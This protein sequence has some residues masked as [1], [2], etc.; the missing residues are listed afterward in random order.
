MEAIYQPT[1]ICAQATAAGHGAI[2][3]IRISGPSA[4][5]VLAEIF[6]SV[7]G[8]KYAELPARRMLFGTISASDGALIDE[9]LAVAF[10]APGSYTGEDSAEIYCHGSD[11]IVSELIKLLMA[12]GVRLASA[13]EFTKRAF[14]NGR[15]DLAQAE[16]VADLISS[17]TKAAHDVALNQMKGG[18]SEELASMRAELLNIVSLM[19]LELDFSEEDVEFADRSRLRSLVAEVSAH[20]GRLID[21]FALG[22]VIK[23]GVPVAIIGSTNTGKSTLLNALLREER[24]IVSDIAG[25]TRD[26]IE[27][28]VNIEGV[29]FRFIDTAGIRSTDETIE[30]IGIERTYSTLEKAS[31][32]LLMLDATRADSFMA[33]LSD[34]VPRLRAD[35]ELFVLVNKVDLVGEGAE[36]HS[37]TSTYGLHC[38][39]GGSLNADDYLSGSKDNSLSSSGGNNPGFSGS[40]ITN[41]NGVSADKTAETDGSPDQAPSAH[42]A[43]SQADSASD[44]MDFANKRISVDNVA[45]TDN[46]TVATLIGKIRTAAETLGLHPTAILPLCAKRRIG[47][48]ALCKALVASRRNLTSGSSNGTMVTNLRHY[49]ALCEARTALE[50]VSVGLDDCIPTEF[51]SMDIRSCIDAIGTITGEVSNDE[52]LGNIF[53]NF[54]IGK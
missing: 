34:L 30:R 32:V 38:D 35:Q 4:L 40:A 6:T 39:E 25:T 52:V 8:R 27:D 43:T 44:N 45:S 54:C 5:K 16:A 49:E 10:P 31:D 47:I 7:R 50:R 2:A 42:N 48:D 37:H 13:G 1:T 28:T 17:E 21:S 36:L 22:N 12:H 29:T 18:Y 14:L 26:T 24:A 41:A 46:A 33:S 23:N 19:E 9:V 53:R 51:V 20:I 3:I 11:Y 15:L